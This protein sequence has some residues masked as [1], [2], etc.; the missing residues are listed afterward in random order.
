[1]FVTPISHQRELVQAPSAHGDPIVASMQQQLDTFKKFMATAF[2]ASI[3]PVA[4]T[5]KMPFSDR[6]DAFQLPPGYK[7]PHLEFYDGIGDSIKHLQGYIVHMTI[8]SNN[9]DVYAKAFSN[10][11]TGKARDCGTGQPVDLRETVLRKEGNVLPR[12]SPVWER[13]QRDMGQFA[14]KPHKGTGQTTTP[15]PGRMRGNPR[16]RDQNS[17]YEYHRE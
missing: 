15:V 7:L 1:M 5:T 9:R 10:S 12:E 8:T 17:Y 14:G 13:I 11:L 4:P 2:P 6:L 16:K 3:A